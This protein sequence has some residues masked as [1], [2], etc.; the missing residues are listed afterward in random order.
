VQ[1]DSFPSSPLSKGALIARMEGGETF[2]FRPFYG[3]TPPKHGGVSDAIFSQFHP[4]DFKIDG[5]RFVLAEQWMMA[6]KARLFG[7]EKTRAQIMASVDPKVCKALGR[8]V[9]DF[10][11]ARW[12]A[13]RFD[14]VVAGNLAKFGQNP[15]MKAHLLAT[16][17]EVLVEAAPHDVVWGIGYGREGEKVGQPTQWRGLN[18]L[19]FALMQVRDLLRLEA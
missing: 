14:L 9:R 3:H 8:R 19:G 15:A 4:A 16:G 11:E 10:D 12:A 7:D 13:A 1:L 5:E 18:L 6:G 2:R 17:D